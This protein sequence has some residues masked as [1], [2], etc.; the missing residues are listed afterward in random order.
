VQIHKMVVDIEWFLWLEQNQI[1]SYLVFN[2][3]SFS[4]CARF[5]VKSYCS[6]FTSFITKGF[7]AS[8]SFTSDSNIK[9]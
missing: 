9:A 2:V 8:V 5:F 3:S 7:D 4:I 6:I 1:I